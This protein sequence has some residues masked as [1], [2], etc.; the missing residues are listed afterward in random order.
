[1]K[2]WVNSTIS[3]RCVLTPVNKLHEFRHETFTISNLM[4]LCVN[5]HSWGG[6]GKDY[7][8]ML[9]VTLKKII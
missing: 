3:Q 4:F 2:Y 8:L 6:T 1:M 7:V 5:I 9:N